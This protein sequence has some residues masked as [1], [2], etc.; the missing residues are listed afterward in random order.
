M[1]YDLVVI[2][3]S[4]GGL[5]ALSTLLSGLPPELALA[6]TIVQ[7]RSKESDGT[8]TMMLQ[9]YS[10]LPVREAEDKDE[11]LPGHVYLA[12][13]DYHLLVEKGSF[14]L[15]TDA[16]VAPAASTPVEAVRLWPHSSPEIVG[17]RPEADRNSITAMIR[18]SIS[19]AWMSRRPQ[20]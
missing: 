6:L 18:R 1:R 13:P 4:F 16:P 11:I 12:P 20:A 9:E 3:T 17:S 2:G 15:S 19:P 10:P 5:R 7:H 14:A 8:L